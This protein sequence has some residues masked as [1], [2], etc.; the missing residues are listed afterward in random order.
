M[1]SAL[2]RGLILVVLI[3]CSFLLLWWFAPKGEDR[4]GWLVTE[5]TTGDAIVVER[6]GETYTVHMF[7][8]WAPAPGE[9][10]FAESR[11]HLEEGIK[12]VEVVLEPRPA[13]PGS[14]PEASIDNASAREMYVE[15]AGRD[16]GLAQIEAGH[17]VASGD[18]HERADAYWEAQRT[19]QDAGLYACD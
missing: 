14:Q 2:S 6:D 7:G 9:C 16:V 19:A 3:T 4:G 1:T 10:G 17:A 18:V 12:G 5:V 13:E 15:F 11:E 8:V